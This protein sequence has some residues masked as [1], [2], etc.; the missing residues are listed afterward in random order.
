MCK[1]CVASALTIEILHHQLDRE[2]ERANKYEKLLYAVTGIQNETPSEPKEMQPIPGK[3][4]WTE[5]R[6]KLEAADR[7]KLEVPAD[8]APEGQEL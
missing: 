8:L 6:R 1:G 7:K 3:I 5:L 4:S 2:T